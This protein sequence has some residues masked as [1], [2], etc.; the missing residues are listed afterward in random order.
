MPDPAA[1]K[2]MVKLLLTLP[3]PILRLMSGGGVVYKGGA[4]LDP[5]FQFLAYQ[6]RNGP[7]MSSVTA[8]EARA[9]AKAGFALVA[10]NPEPGVG[11]ENQ[12]LDGPNGEI[13]VRVYRPERRDPEAP[14]LV[15]LHMGGGVIGDLETCHVFCSQIAKAAATTIVSVDY[16]LAPEHRHP[17]G[18]EDCLAAY[19]HVRDHAEAYGAKPGRVAIGGESMG[20]YFS[21]IICQDLKAAGEAQPEYQLLLYPCLDAVSDA[22]SMTLHADAFPL[23]LDT[24]N[25]FFAQYLPPDADPVSP[26][27]SPMRAEDLSGLAPAIIVAA[28]FDPLSDQ[29]E[30]Y[31]KKLQAA[32]GKVVFRKYASLPHAFTS[33]NI[34]ASADKASREVAELVARASQGALFS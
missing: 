33:Y 17:A 32:G 29:S 24:M 2:T 3:S 31:A 6:A 9:G 28:G 16:R 23:S 13:P 8:V 4:T 1:Q 18:L 30:A 19:R 26:R 12:T 15:Y 14:A 34:V 20:G 21:A 27:V 7:P 5:R 22:P 25:W 11:F 10:G